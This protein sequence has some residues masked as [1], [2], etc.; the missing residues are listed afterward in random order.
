MNQVEVRFS[1][2]RGKAEFP[3][4]CNSLIALEAPR[5]STFPNLS[6][7]AGP[8]GGID[9]QWD[10]NAEA[11]VIDSPFTRKGWNVYQF[12]SVDIGVGRDKAL[13]ELCDR[14]NGAIAELISRLELPA[15]PALYVLFTN[16]ELGIDRPTR[17][18]RNSRQ[19][20]KFER[21][22][23]SLLAN[24][25]INIQIEIFDAGKI[26][27]AVRK[28]RV[29]QQTWFAERSSSTWEEAYKREVN[30]WR[31]D[32]PFKGREAEVK[33][34][35]A[36][37][38][39][40]AVR[41]IALT[42]VNSI[43]KT[44]LALECTRSF[45]GVTF[46]A[47]NTSTL[48][49]EGVASWASSGTGPII[50]VVEDPTSGDAERLARQA[51]GSDTSTK[52][53]MTILSQKEIPA[54][55]FGDASRV[56]VRHIGPLDD[57]AAQQLL[58]QLNSD[59]DHRARDWVLEQ[60]GGNPGIIIGAAM[61][62]SELRR[63]V[64]GLRN[65]V[66]QNWRQRLE[67]RFGA[68][69]VL[70]ASALSILSGVRLDHAS[71]IQFLLNLIAPNLS[72]PSFQF[73]IAELEGFGC[74]RRRGKTVSVV[75]PIFAAGLANDLIKAV[76]NMPVHLFAKLDNDGRRRLLDRLV[77]LDLPP[78]VWDQ[79]L[80]LATNQDASPLNNRL[81]T[82]ASLA[83]AMP[84]V[85]ASFLDRELPNL[86][87]NIEL[88]EHRR[89]PGALATIIDELVEDPETALEGFDLLTRLAV[90]DSTHNLSTSS[91]NRFRECFVWWY[92]RAITYR[93]R[94][95]TI[96]SLFKSPNV[97]VRLLGV[98]ALVIATDIPRSLSGRGVV[99]RRL[100]PEPT[101]TLIRDRNE[102]LEW[103]LNRRLEIAQSEDI[104]ARDAALKELENVIGPLAETLPGETAMRA[105]DKLLK[106]HFGG[107][108]PLETRNL[109]HQLKWTRGLYARYRD[110]G[111]GEWKKSWSAMVERLETAIKKLNSGPF[112]DR[113]K[114]AIGPTFEHEEVEF[115][116]RKLYTPEVRVIHLAREAVAH[117]DYMID[118]WD[119]LVGG[120]TPNAISFVGELGR[121]D[122]SRVFYS[123]LLRRADTW[124]WAVLHGVYLAGA[125]EAE[126]E[127]SEARL[128]ELPPQ[129]GDSNLAALLAYQQTGFT[130]NNQAR[131]RRLID[132]GTVG[133]EHIA[134]AFSY[135]RWLE[136]LSIEDVRAVLE[137]IE[138]G[139][140]MTPRLAEVISL[141]LHPH[142][143][144]PVELIP[145]SKRVLMAAQ[146]INDGYGNLGY[147]C[148]QIALGIAKTD[149][150]TGFS[151][152]EEMLAQINVETA[153]RLYGTWN[154]LEGP[155]SREFLTF[156]RNSGP[157]QFYRI[158]VK[159]DR[160]R[161]VPDLRANRRTP[162]LDLENH[163][164]I[165]QRLAQADAGKAEAFA[166]F[167]V[168][169]QP[170][171]WEFAVLL[172]DGYPNSDRIHASLRS[173]VLDQTG[174]ASR[175]EHITDA[176][177]F[178]S[179]AL[180]RPALSEPSRRWLHSLC[181]VID[182]RKR[183]RAKYFDE[184]A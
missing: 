25:P 114:L 58:D 42:G 36:W 137:Y 72:E 104:P 158:L 84:R 127:W 173:A 23:A 103:A 167:A 130:G 184:D 40:P 176:E 109:L 2:E 106:A 135:G 87:R 15:E 165:I 172:L 171:F 29:L 12:K 47:D 181:Q 100:G 116:G 168:A 54:I 166:E 62:G 1:S 105:I 180:Q 17:T 38:I 52:L 73:R 6:T 178:I 86:L 112:R 63:S 111:P 74:I 163:R 161:Y 101:R 143:A 59:L 120:Q 139:E 144:I 30:Q 149:V 155:S 150:A 20:D 65:R 98:S 169:A 85:V 156:L 148:D 43:G 64:G 145:I 46:F 11:N 13:R 160:S 89:N 107:A 117:P 128:T 50:L 4:F 91:V 77:A 147:H 133:R 39:D 177:R 162:L 49:S 81:E 5:M 183:E 126:P 66:T 153:L 19:N 90:H 26:E 61:L 57:A 32:A 7:K 110:E 152:L 131:F 80:E 14:V 56:Q 60:A 94:Q 45:S 70:A 174:F 88:V 140:N 179:E 115:E 18:K 35:G 37:L 138:R 102:F 82:L 24:A 95:S 175:Y 75:P 123:E 79:I 142:K 16:L 41:V 154:L 159:I 170:G 93:Y 157:E 28:H 78:D 113:L 44:R 141:Y 122:K 99:P 151:L 83:R 164:E 76:A 146:S 3:S 33:Q 119:V 124:Q 121:S 96:E 68:E 22:R 34:L 53:L 27:A 67:H 31:L 118:A 132:A 71:E 97:A 69:S 51:L 10:L 9:G 182:E 92:P 21:L 134:L 136:Q 108:I 129:R 125:Q 8:D 55:V 48:L